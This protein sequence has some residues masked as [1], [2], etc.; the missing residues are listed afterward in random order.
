MLS[1]AYYDSTSSAALQTKVLRDVESVEQLSRQLAEPA[2]GAIMSILV[3]IGVTAWRMPAFLPVF[4][5]LVPIVAGLRHVMMERVKRTNTA[6]RKELEGMTAQ[7]GGM[8]SMIPV[9]RAHAVEPEEIARVESRFGRV[10][11]AGQ[12]FDRHATLFGAATW[13]AFMLLQLGVLVTAAWLAFRGTLP[14]APGD[15]VLLA[16]YFQA[17][18]MSVMQ[19]NAMLPAVTRGLDGL[20]S[21]GEVLECPDIEENRGKPAVGDVQGAFRFENVSFDY[22]VRG[23]SRTALRE[24]NLEVA[25]G[26]TIGLIGP[27]GSGKSTLMSLVIG[28]HRP[29]GGRLLLDGRD[30]NEIDLRS[31]RARLAVVSQ[32]TILFEGTLRENIVYGLSDIEESRLR[33]AVE[34]ANAAEFIAALPRGLDTEI[35][36]RG[37]RLS[38]GQRQRI[39]I[40]RALLRDPRVLILDEATSALD[41]ASESVV[42]EALDRLMVGRTTFIVAHRLH[43][44]RKATRIVELAQGRLIE[45][46]APG[47]ALAGH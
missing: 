35:G 33:A 11:D 23:E 17:V 7:V 14:L 42:Q 38:G 47:D 40:A 44:L 10:S 5:L 13:V 9:T 28:F 29:T 15:M 18:V 46:G 21:I 19:L 31:Y 16:T 37:A 20:R 26:E 4:L 25:P 45:R 27:S 2:V 39:A 34:A 24:V 41:T 8:I 6:F 30:M 32:Q 43:T 1:I 3:A 12:R 36:E 22:E